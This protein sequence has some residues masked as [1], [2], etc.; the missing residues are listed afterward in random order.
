L[1]ELFVPLFAG[2]IVTAFL[3]LANEMISLFQKLNL[4]NIPPEA[5]AKYLIL[6]LPWI[7]KFTIPMGVAM[8]AALAISRITRDGELTAMRT[9]GFSIR[10][11]MRMVLITG[12]IFGAA[13][14]YNADVLTPLAEKQKIKIANELNI[15]AILPQFE[16]NKAIQLPPYVAMFGEVTEKNDTMIL[17]DILLFERQKNNEFQVYIAPEGTYEKGV[18]TIKKP[19]VRMF[20][21]EAFV[22]IYDVD[23]VVINQ[24]IDIQDFMVGGQVDT[25]SSQDLRRRIQEAKR[26]RGSTRNL[27]LPLYDRQAVSFA[28]VVFAAMAGV[29]AIK[30]SKGSAFQGLLMSLFCLWIFFNF[31][32]IMVTIVGKNGWLPPM[33][34]AWT[35]T[36]TFALLTAYVGW[37]Q[38]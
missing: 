36:V 32:I 20:Q 10:R 19:R 28:C 37:K 18:W 2:T 12:A 9:A 8:G 1:K 24:R 23:E 15:V 26:S 25:V 5:I 31:H 13:S 22:D 38:E 4:N 7:L 29:L 34:A 6:M 16:R 11:I 14:Y 3:F 33:I 17:K 21:D 27:E 30:F 35:A